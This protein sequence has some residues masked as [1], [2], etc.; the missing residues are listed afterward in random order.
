ME[1]VRHSQ[2]WFVVKIT[3]FIPIGMSAATTQIPIHSTNHWNMRQNQ[4]EI[5][6]VEMQRA[7]KR[8]V[9]VF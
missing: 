5:P 9:K 2:F 3:Q 7:R 4:R 6:T 8:G 1:I